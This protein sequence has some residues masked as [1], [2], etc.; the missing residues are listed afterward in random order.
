M[1]NDTREYQ[2]NDDNWQWKRT[3]QGNGRQWRITHNGN[4]R[5]WGMKDNWELYTMGNVT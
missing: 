2:L 3:D 5:Q 1:R 4:D